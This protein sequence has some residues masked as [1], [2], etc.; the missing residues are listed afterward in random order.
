MEKKEKKPPANAIQSLLNEL[1][2]H[3]NTEIKVGTG[4]FVT[5]GILTR[6]MKGRY[7]SFIEVR[8]LTS[9]R[10]SVHPI[11][12]SVISYEEVI[13]HGKESNKISG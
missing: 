10:L 11:N 13:S 2:K 3:I 12:Y 6:I 5:T 1:E 8:S 7:V 4:R 9:S